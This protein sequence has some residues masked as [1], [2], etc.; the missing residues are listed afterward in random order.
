MHR[1][2]GFVA[3]FH[4]LFLASAMIAAEPS[5]SGAV[6]HERQLAWQRMEYYGFV[7][8]GLNTWTNREWGYG[9]EDPK[10]FN[11]SDFDARRIARQFREA[12]MKGIVEVVAK[13]KLPKTAPTA[14]AKSN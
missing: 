1:C 3:I 10:L 6:P 4:A 2:F 12:G 5:P 11:P 14:A 8:F 13:G 7:H 9:D